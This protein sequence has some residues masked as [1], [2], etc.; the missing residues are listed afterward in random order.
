MVFCSGNQFMDGRCAAGDP[1]KRNHVFRQV[2]FGADDLVR[3]G[4]FHQPPVAH[5]FNMLAICRP[6]D[7]N[8]FAFWFLRIVQFPFFRNLPTCRRRLMAFPIFVAH[9][10][11]VFLRLLLYGV[12][13]FESKTM[14]NAAFPSPVVVFNRGLETCFPWRNEHGDHSQAQT[15]SH[16]FSQ[17]VR[18]AVAL[19]NRRIV[20]L[21]V[22]RQSEF[23]P[24]INQL[25]HRVFRGHTA[26]RPRT[27]KSAVQRN[28]VQ[29]LKHFSACDAKVL[30]E[31]ELIKFDDLPGDRF[32]IPSCRRRFVTPSPSSVEQTFSLQ[33]SVDRRSRRQ[34]AATTLL[35][36]ANNRVGSVFAERTFLLEVFAQRQY[37]SFDL[38]RDAIDRFRHSVRP[39]IPVDAIQPFACGPPDQSSNGRFSNTKLCC[40]FPQRFPS[41]NRFNRPPPILLSQTDRFVSW[42]NSFKKQTFK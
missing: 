25:S 1:I 36:F 9:S 19:K 18:S 8:D 32:Q 11:N 23:R 2:N 29:H 13:V 30:D 26:H 39:V 14:P 24:E 31:I 37:T 34:H 15:K 33:N 21:R 4:S 6:A 41:A 35:H 27:D 12:H 3:S 7:E 20:E 42:S 38:R 40:N 16:D 10:R 5:D 28:P 17:R 22:V